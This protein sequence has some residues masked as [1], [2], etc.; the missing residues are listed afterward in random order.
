M[1]RHYIKSIIIFIILSSII[2][3]SST[4]NLNALSQVKMP[5]N[6]II[7]IS[8]GCGYGQ[9]EAT[10]Y[11]QYGKLG[12][13]IYEKF[14]VKLAMSTYSINGSYDTNEIWKDFNIAYNGATDSAAS[15]TAI[16]SGIKTYDTAIGVDNQGN[17]VKTITEK[18]KELGRSTGVVTSVQFCHSTPASFV[19]HNSYRNNY[20]EIA[21]EM[22]LSSKMDVIMGAGNPMF[23]DDGIAIQNPYIYD[24]VGGQD[25]WN[26]LIKGNIESSDIDND[27]KN[28]KWTLIQTRDEFKKLGRGMTPKR[29]IGIPQVGTTLQQARS[30][31]TQANP[32]EIPINN[33]VP[34][35]AEMS[36]ASLNVLDNNKKGFFLMVEGGAIDWASHS[37]QTGRM[38]EEEIEFNKSV[39]SV[40][41]WVNKYSNWND[42][43]L[44]VTGDHECGYLTG[45]N[46]NPTWEK[47][48]NNG[49]GK[50]PSVQWNSSS[51]TNSLIPFFAKGNYS[52]L[53]EYYANEKD[54]KR[55]KYIQNSEIA[56]AIFKIMK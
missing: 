10:D 41:E 7:M 46:S 33:N 47:I 2:I 14:P 45:P 20:S 32:Y 15:A 37:N 42:T 9:I 38:I 27:G 8:D 18:A 25:I 34:T 21:K 12:S 24:Y 13:Q 3:L 48:I 40:V 50:L 19:A 36:K 22:I 43:L 54:I 6:I 23:D 31:N 39:E 1:T 44:I 4:Q 51:H 35:L 55:G 53:F 49:K 29:L 28:D 5:K 56:K 52:N 17:S 16:A 11:Y 26:E 30:G